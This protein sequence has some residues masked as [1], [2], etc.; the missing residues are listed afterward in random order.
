MEKSRTADPP[1]S[2]SH[3]SLGT[4]NFLA[5]LLQNHTCAYDSGGPV[6]YCMIAA[7]HGG[8]E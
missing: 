4:T 6:A 5:V 7:E 2:S 3:G 1:A 8:L